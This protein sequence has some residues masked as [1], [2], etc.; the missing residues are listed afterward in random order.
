MAQALL[1][2]DRPPAVIQDGQPET[3]MAAYLIDIPAGS[4]ALQA[5]AKWV[6]TQSVPVGTVARVIDIAAAQTANAYST[7]RLDSQWVAT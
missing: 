7:Y 5:A 3:Q 4:N 1:I 2:M 6:Q